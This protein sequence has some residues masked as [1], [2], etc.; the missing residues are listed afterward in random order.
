LVNE[1]GDKRRGAPCCAFSLPPGWMHGGTWPVNGDP[2]TNACPREEAFSDRRGGLDS[3]QLNEPRAVGHTQDISK[4]KTYTRVAD[5]TDEVNECSR[6]RLPFVSFSVSLVSR[7][8][9]LS[10]YQVSGV[11][12]AYRGKRKPP[13]TKE[14]ANK[15]TRRNCAHG[16]KNSIQQQ[17]V[18][19]FLRT[20]SVTSSH[21]VST[22]ERAIVFLLSSFARHL[23]HPAPR[24]S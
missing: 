3:T 11:P 2:V 16:E 24:A 21:T 12:P 5:I 20:P 15:E 23:N 13:S 4:L 10:I 8:A 6:L 17:I 1:A 7:L 19:F 9:R 14:P 22:S 18:S